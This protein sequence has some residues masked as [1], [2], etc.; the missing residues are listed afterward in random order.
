[1]VLAPDI[2][3]RLEAQLR[4]VRTVVLPDTAHTI[5]LERPDEFR[6]LALDFLHEHAG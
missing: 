4:D 2:A 5:P 3:A 1:M 6:S